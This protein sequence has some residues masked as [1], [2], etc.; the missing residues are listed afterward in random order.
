MKPLTVILIFLAISCSNESLNT[1]HTNWKTIA[2]GGYIFDFPPGFKLIE[3]Q[4]EDS[5]VGKVKGDSIEFTFDFGR[6]TGQQQTSEEYLANG[7]WKFD[8]AE[9]FMKP[10]V[11]Y[12]QDNTPKVAVLNIRPATVKDSLLSGGCDYVARCRHDTTEFDYP[13]FLPE[14]MKEL[15]FAVDTVNNQYRKIVYTNRPQYNGAEIYIRGIKSFD[16][17]INNYL[18]LGMGA[19]NL[20]K[21][22]LKLALE[23][24]N[25]VRVKVK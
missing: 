25:T 21:K 8:L 15:L 12:G 4:G 23:I 13:V 18:A 11:S 16:S 19:G 7:D 6:Y 20:T 2:V 24:F 5:Y 10:G 3:E 1:P 22:Q 14:E 17:S 9:R